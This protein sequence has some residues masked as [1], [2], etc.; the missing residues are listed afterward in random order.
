MEPILYY[1]TI[2]PPV[3]AVLMTIKAL[4]YKV[5]LKKIDLFKV[6]QRK[7]EFL[8]VCINQDNQEVF[9]DMNKMF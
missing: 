7:E 6:E 5:E 4:N 3:R 2:S 8:K 9:F 1:D